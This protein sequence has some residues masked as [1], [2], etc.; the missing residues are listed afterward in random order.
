MSLTVRDL[1]YCDD[2]AARRLEAEGWTIDTNA[3]STCHHGRHRPHIAWRDIKVKV[4]ARKRR[5]GDS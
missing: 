3:L 4:A 5:D 1:Q 2:D